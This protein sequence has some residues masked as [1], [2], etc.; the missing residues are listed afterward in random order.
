M[1]AADHN[2]SLHHAGANEVA[3]REPCFRPVAEPEPAD[4]RG[5]AL[6]RDP[7]RRELEPALEQL[8]AGEEVAKR[9]VDRRDVARGAGQ[10]RPPERTDAAAEERPDVRGNEPRIVERVGDPRVARLTAEVVSVIEDVAA[11]L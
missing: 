8:V 1:I 3:D 4:P 5:E 6:E 10:G 2:G 9:A 7:F 11:R